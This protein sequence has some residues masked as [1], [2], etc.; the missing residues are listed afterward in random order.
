[1]G[2][3]PLPKSGMKSMI[4]KII[5]DVDIMAFQWEL[6]AVLFGLFPTG[7]VKI[8]SYASETQHNL[9]ELNEHM[10]LSSSSIWT[11]GMTHACES[12]WQLRNHPT[13]IVLAI[14][15]RSS[16]A[17]PFTYSF[18]VRVYLLHLS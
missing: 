13:A 3:C 5:E 17:S 11:S 18:Q 7:K 10:G 2:S 4:Y 14:F 15:L 8:F 6:L 9:L 1:M 12:V 16:Y